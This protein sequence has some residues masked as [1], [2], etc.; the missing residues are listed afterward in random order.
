MPQDSV[1]FS[2]GSRTVWIDGQPLDSLGIKM[3]LAMVDRSK[4]FKQL[5]KRSLGAVSAVYEGR[6]DGETQVSA[7]SVVEAAPL[8]G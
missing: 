2:G 4:T 7:S 6:N 1:L 5:C 3:N 8:S